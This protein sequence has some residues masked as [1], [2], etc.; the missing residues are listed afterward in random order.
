MPNDT[1]LRSNASKP[2]RNEVKCC[3]NL[4]KSKVILQFR[5]CLGTMSVSLEFT[6]CWTLN[7][8]R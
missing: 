5:W 4:L 7:P 2:S 1:V 8:S 6:R 3:V